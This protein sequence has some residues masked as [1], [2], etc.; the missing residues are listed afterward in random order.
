MDK[1]LYEFARNIIMKATE[2]SKWSENNINYLEYNLNRLS[3]HI[4][5]SKTEEDIEPIKF[6]TNLVLSY[7]D[8]TEE[9]LTC[10]SSER[11]YTL[12]RQILGFLLKKHFNMKEIN[13]VKLVGRRERSLVYS[14][15]K[16]VTDAIEVNDIKVTKGLYIIEAILLRKGIIDKRHVDDDD[17]ES[18]IL[19]MFK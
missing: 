15:I 9:E 5:I 14:Y 17:F 7:Y 1:D 19:N 18:S 13:I 12:P 3:D 10:K 2:G 8:I 6:V 11:K 4:F 16:T